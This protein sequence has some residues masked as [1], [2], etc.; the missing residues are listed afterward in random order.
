MLLRAELKG[1]LNTEGN[2]CRK[3]EHTEHPIPAPSRVLAS[4]LMV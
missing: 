1:L 3:P 4:L 2:I